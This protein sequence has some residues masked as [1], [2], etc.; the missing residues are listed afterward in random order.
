VA[1]HVQDLEGNPLLGYP[2]HVWGGGIDQTIMSGANTRH[3]TIYGS[4]A[5]WEQFFDNKPKPIE[6][7]VR[8]HDNQGRPISEEI[9]INMPGY[10]GA[11]LAYVIFTQNH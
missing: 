10:C 1:G 8:L 11:A 5:A 7:R 6:I 4:E 2:V 9:V 3:N